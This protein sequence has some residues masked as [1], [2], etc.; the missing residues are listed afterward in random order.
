[1]KKVSK[2]KLEQLLRT[3]VK[4]TMQTSG[5]VVEISPDFRVAV[6]SVEKAGVRII[7][8]A[9]GYDSE[10]LDLFVS[11]NNISQLKGE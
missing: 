9:N 5:E 2:M 11:G 7:I 1:M 10:T 4:H 3:K 6:Q 8:H